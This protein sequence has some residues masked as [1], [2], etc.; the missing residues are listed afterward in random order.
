ML[1]II[2][3]YVQVELSCTQTDTHTYTERNYS[4]G[5]IN[6]NCN[7]L[8]PDRTVANSYKTTYVMEH[9][10]IRLFPLKWSSD[11]LYYSSR[12]SL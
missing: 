12:G 6:P 3:Q 1:I 8:D 4:C 10:K 9:V 5:L 11:I 2:V 7:N